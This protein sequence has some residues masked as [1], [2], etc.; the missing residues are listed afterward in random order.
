MKIFIA[1][2]LIVANSWLYVS[3]IQKGDTFLAI[4]A[5]LGIVCGIMALAIDTLI[6]LWRQH[7]NG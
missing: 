5:A 4:V 7:N 2:L 6:R 1:I 3:C